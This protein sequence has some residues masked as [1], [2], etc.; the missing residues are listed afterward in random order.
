MH[1]RV[2]LGDLTLK[3]GSGSTPRGG[4]SVY[5][6]DGVAFIRSQNVYDNSFSFAG[7]ARISDEAAHALRGVTVEAGDVLVNITGES[8]TRTCVVDPEALPARVSQHVAIVRPDP[9][10]LDPD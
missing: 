2:R 1:E 4:K 7:L 10:L 9:D 8:V 3:V 5:T 6:D